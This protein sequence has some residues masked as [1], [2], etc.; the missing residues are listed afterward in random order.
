MSAVVAV[1]PK[2]ICCYCTRVYREGTE[3]ASHGACRECFELQLAAL[4]CNGGPDC[5]CGAHLFLRGVFSAR[6]RGD[7][8]AVAGGGERLPRSGAAQYPGQPHGPAVLT[9]EEINSAVA[10]RVR[11]WKLKQ[12][13]LST[14]PYWLAIAGVLAGMWWAL[15]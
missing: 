8:V 14:W 11:F 7:A 5:K 1:L 2:A 6:E 10:W 3:P 13:V 15:P 4:K 9:A 12:A